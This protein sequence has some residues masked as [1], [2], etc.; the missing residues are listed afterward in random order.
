VA[1]RT[2]YAPGTFSWVECATTDLDGATAFYE[3]LFGWDRADSPIDDTDVYRMFQLNGKSV[4]AAF[5]QREEE[6]SHGVPPHW[7]NYVTVASVDDAAARISELGGN[8]LMD[9]FDVFDSGRMVAFSDPTSA[10]LSL[11]EPRAHIGAQLVND[12]GSF[13]W[14]ELS[15]TDMD[16]AKSFYA[17]LLGWSYEDVG[18]VDMPYTTIRNGDRM[19]GGIRPLGDQEKQ[20]GIPPNWMPYFT[21]A[22]I[23]Q[24]VSKVGELGGGVMVG[25]MSILQS[26]RIAIARDPQGAVF[27]LFEGETED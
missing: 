22:E 5:R 12:P 20:M 6:R 2:E 1:E 15:T 3:G 9:P 17:D 25:P 11:W 24:S 14:N 4:A 13:T 10:I 7:N 16:R 23:E 26:S 19:N 8:P 21:S 18:T 27:G